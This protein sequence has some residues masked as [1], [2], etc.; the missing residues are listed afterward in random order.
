MDKR[1]YYSE[2]SYLC[3]HNFF[4]FPYTISLS[5]SFHYK[6]TFSKIPLLLKML[7]YLHQEYLKYSRVLGNH[8]PKIKNSI[9]NI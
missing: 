2:N 3:F 1:K 8:P 6:L 5:N 9:Q 7:T 4:S